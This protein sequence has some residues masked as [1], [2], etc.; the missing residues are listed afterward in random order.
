[1][2]D[3]AGLCLAP[4]TYAYMKSPNG[5]E[6]LV[7]AALAIAILLWL[8]RDNPIVRGCALSRRSRCAF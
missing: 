3:N 7:I 6:G 4:W 1:M 8:N 5:K 2:C